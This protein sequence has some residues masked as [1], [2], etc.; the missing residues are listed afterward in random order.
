MSDK[1]YGIQENYKNNVRLL[2]YAFHEQMLK[3]VFVSYN[4]NTKGV[5][6]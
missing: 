3:M 4:S 1:F 5:T 2:E 6:N